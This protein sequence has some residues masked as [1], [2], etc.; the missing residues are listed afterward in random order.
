MISKPT[1]IEKKKRI[2]FFSLKKFEVFLTIEATLQNLYVP[3]AIFS[4]FNI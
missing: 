3:D 1:G 2:T 4:L